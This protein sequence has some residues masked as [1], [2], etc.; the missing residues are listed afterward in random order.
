MDTYDTGNHD[1]Q[2]LTCA[3]SDCSLPTLDLG[4]TDSASPFVTSVWAGLSRPG[5]PSSESPTFESSPAEPGDDIDPSYTSVR[6]QAS[7][8]QRDRQHERVQLMRVNSS[9]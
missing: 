2:S 9:D 1:P 5:L 4:E 6:A 7:D 3:V 8:H